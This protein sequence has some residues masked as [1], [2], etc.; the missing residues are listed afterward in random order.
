MS[1]DWSNL[2]LVHIDRLLACSLFH[3]PRLHT[4]IQSTLPVLPLAAQ[5]LRGGKKVDQ[6]F[7]RVVMNGGFF[8]LLV[9]GIGLVVKDTINLGLFKG[10]F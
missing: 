3:S 4:H 7:E 10:L 6:T 5:T 8:A 1:D 2:H 9:L